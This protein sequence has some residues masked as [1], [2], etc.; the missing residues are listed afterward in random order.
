M[1]SVGEKLLYLPLIRN[2]IIIYL[3][4][5]DWVQERSGK[6]GWNCPAAWSSCALLTSQGCYDGLTYEFIAV[7]Y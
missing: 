2:E 4:F 3:F 5:E 6:A 1:Y 7:F